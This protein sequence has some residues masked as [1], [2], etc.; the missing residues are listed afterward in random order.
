MVLNVYPAH[1]E[2]FENIDAL[3]QEKLAIVEGLS[4]NGILVTVDDPDLKVPSGVDSL[5]LVAVRP[6]T[7]A[8]STRLGVRLCCKHLRDGSRRTYTGVAGVVP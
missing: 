2:Y 3:R 4:P 8:L 5:R 1:I 7:C 6:P